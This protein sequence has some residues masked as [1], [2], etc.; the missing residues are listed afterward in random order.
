MTS[1]V[2]STR[3]RDS[4]SSVYRQKFAGGDRMAALE[5]Y[6]FIRHKTLQNKVTFEYKETI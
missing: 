3:A 5:A 2:H 1:E 6:V 4:L